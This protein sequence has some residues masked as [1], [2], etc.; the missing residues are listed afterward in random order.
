MT[1]NGHGRDD[2]ALD[3]LIVLAFLEDPMREAPSPSGP[4]P[5][6]DSADQRALDALGPDLTRR[7]LE[8]D[9]RA[10]GM[11]EGPLPS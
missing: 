9:S 3:A 7:I 2:R 8:E 5:E 11:I 10:T 6:L 4:E 1:R